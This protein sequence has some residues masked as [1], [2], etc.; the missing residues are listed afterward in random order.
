MEHIYQ[1]LLGQKDLLLNA[2]RYE[3]RHRAAENS[4]AYIK[5]LAG[6]LFT[7]DSDGRITFQPA[8]SIIAGFIAKG[9]SNE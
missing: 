2:I 1:P 3:V 5:D 7:E 8:A 9:A 4:T 6:I